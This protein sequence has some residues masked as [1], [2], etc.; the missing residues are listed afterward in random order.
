MPFL[1][2]IFAGRSRLLDQSPSD[3]VFAVA[4]AKLRVLSVEAAIIVESGSP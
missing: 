1:R 2:L 3:A 4:L